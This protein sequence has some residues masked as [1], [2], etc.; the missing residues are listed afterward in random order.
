MPSQGTGSLVSDQ[1]TGSLVN[2]WPQ[3]LGGIPKG[4]G[5]R[6]TWSVWGGV[7]LRH[8]VV[9]CR[10]SSGLARRR[11]GRAGRGPPA[12]EARLS[13]CSAR[14]RRAPGRVYTPLRGCRWR[15]CRLRG[16]VLC[17]QASPRPEGHSTSWGRAKVHTANRWPP[18]NQAQVSLLWHTQMST[19]AGTTRHSFTSAR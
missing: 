3:H 11:G 14:S 1:G 8:R 17:E 16:V 13:V 12:E 9:L 18:Q 19:H 2:A 6:E 7:F 10:L 4:T 15:R 5:Q